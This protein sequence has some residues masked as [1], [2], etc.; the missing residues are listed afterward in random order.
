MRQGTLRFSN[1]S[2]AELWSPPEEFPDLSQ[3]KHIAIDLETCDPDIKTLGPGWATD[4]GIVVGVAVATDFYKGYFPIAHEGGGN[5]DKRLT[6]RWLKD[7]L[8]LPCD[9]IFHNAQYDVGWLRR[10]GHT[11]NGRIIDTMLVASLLDEN[12]FSYS[13][14][15]VGFDFINKTKSEKGLVQAAVEF[16]LDPKAEMWKLPSCYVGPYAEG[17]A[18]LTLELWNYFKT[19]ISN[20]GLTTVF[21]LETAL[22][23]CLVDMT[24]NGIRV[25]L[26]KTEK[27]R[28]SLIQEEKQILKKIKDET[29]VHVE[30]WASASIARV[31]DTLALEYPRTEKGS[32]SFTRVFLSEHKHPIPQ[33]I[34]KV[35]EINKIHGT[36]L[37]TIQKHVAKDGRIH[38]HINQVRGDNGGTVSGRISMNNPNMQQIP[39][40][41]PQF[42]KMV[43]SLFLP[44]E[45]QQWASIDFSQQEPRILVH[46]SQAYNDSQKIGILRG[47]DEFVTNYRDNPKDTDFHTLV[48]EMADIPRKTAKVINLAMMYGMGVFKL[49][50]QLDISKDEAKELTTQYH[51]RVP[52]VKGLQEVVM[53]RLNSRTS[54]GFLRSLLGRKLRFDLWEPDSFQMSKALKREE[55]IAV[56]GETARLKR[57][58]TYKALNRLIQ[59]SAADQTKKA[60][61][62]VYEHGITPLLQVHDE[63]CC[64]VR[65]QE[66]AKE[67]QEIMENALPLEIPS[68][69]DLE[70]GTSWGTIDNVV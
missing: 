51:S 62:K 56:H 10:M 57:A 31:F 14:N 63:L 12:R 61:L 41:H 55:A 27:T 20:Q 38:S 5:I 47:V 32:P 15:A 17:D 7:V 28:Q 42:G 39:A 37:N 58:Y 48:A 26:N 8:A 44:E 29:K 30:M 67:I 9:K 16:G 25:D 70:M 6:N 23:P 3:A 11:I 33:Q 4:N 53:Q 66:E 19:E 69:C 1:I 68:V 22:L 46:Y 49:S 54:E 60:M 2:D 24:W 21:D 35:R 18:E 43:R 59:A 13:L 65:T 52:F 64:S 34:A 36:F 40:R 45:D 50:Q